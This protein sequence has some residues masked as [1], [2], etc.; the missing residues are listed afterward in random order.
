MMYELK[1]ET[2]K[3]RQRGSGEDRGALGNGGQRPERVLVTSSP[4]GAFQ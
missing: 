3:D 4:V 2:P 1:I